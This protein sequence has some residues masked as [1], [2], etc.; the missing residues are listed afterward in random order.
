MVDTPCC[1]HI[2][3]GRVGNKT[4]EVVIGVAM[5]RRVFHK[6]SIPTEYAKVFVREVTDMRYT[7]YPLDYV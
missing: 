6:N 7:D 3:L 2:S 1:L 4:K 5:S